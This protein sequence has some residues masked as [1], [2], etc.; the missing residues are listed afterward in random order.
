MLKLIFIIFWIAKP[1]YFKHLDIC[2]SIK[3]NNS[4]SNKRNNNNKNDYN[5]KNNNNKNV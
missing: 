2:I 4:E 1:L 5:Y 3:Y